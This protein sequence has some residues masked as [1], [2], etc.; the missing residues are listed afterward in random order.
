MSAINAKTQFMRQYYRFVRPGAIRIGAVSREEPFD[1]LAF[2][3]QDGGYVVVVKCNV[4][5]AFSIGSLPGGTYGI[6]YTTAGQFG[7]ELPDPTIRSGQALQASI[8]AAGVL[9]VYAMS[10]I[11]YRIPA[12]EASWRI[13][14]TR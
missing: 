12:R 13:R 9:T 7:V 8:L 4:G 11:V 14:A 1:P 6:S 2:I 10:P 3:N 5:G